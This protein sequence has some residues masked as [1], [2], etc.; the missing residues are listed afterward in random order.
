MFRSDARRRSD[1]SWFDD[2]F[3]IRATSTVTAQILLVRSDEVVHERSLI[4]DAVW[5]IR[6]GLEQTTMLKGHEI[7]V[8]NQKYVTQTLVDNRIENETQSEFNNTEHV[9]A[10]GKE[11]VAVIVTSG[12]PGAGNWT[13]QSRPD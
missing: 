5:P 12:E 2:H 8:R 10:S 13:G 6:E 7:I 4:A 9:M 11:V 1:D 3:D